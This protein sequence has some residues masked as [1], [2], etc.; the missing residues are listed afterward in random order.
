[1]TNDL[2]IYGENICA[3]P[4]ILGSPSSYITL[5]PILSEF[6]YVWGKFLFSFLS[7]QYWTLMKELTGQSDETRWIFF[8]GP[9][10]YIRAFCM[11]SV[12]GWLS[13][14]SNI[15]MCMK[16]FTKMKKSYVGLLW[17]GF[18]QPSHCFPGPRAALCQC[19][20]FYLRLLRSPRRVSERKKSNLHFLILEG[21]D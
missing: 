4:Y 9:L 13:P 15:Y 6:P 21:V 2:L 5:H 8:C 16:K 17:K 12:I 1:M 7:V 20:Q 3:C 19:F 10:S 18:P 11:C 14:E